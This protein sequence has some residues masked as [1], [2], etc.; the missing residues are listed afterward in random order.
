[1]LRVA[2]ESTDVA[3]ALTLAFRGELTRYLHFELALRLDSPS[4]LAT[5][6]LEKFLSREMD[7]SM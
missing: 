3:F 5:L 6:G 2:W 7:I 4:L 1:M